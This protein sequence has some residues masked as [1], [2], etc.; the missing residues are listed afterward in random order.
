MSDVFGYADIV[1]LSVSWLPRSW[2]SLWGTTPLVS[3]AECLTIRTKSRRRWMGRPSAGAREGR[4]SYAV[5]LGGPVLSTSPSWAARP[6]QRTEEQR[7]GW[8]KVILT[9]TMRSRPNLM[10]LASCDWG[11]PVS[12]PRVAHPRRGG[13]SRSGAPSGALGGKP[14]VSLGGEQQE[15]AGAGVADHH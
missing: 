15:E 11:R 13:Q 5:W 14:H 8:S 3:T 6:V 12:L 1:A 2:L 4:C 9:W 10:G 7:A